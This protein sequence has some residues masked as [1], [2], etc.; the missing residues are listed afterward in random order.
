LREQTWNFEG[1]DLEVFK[2]RV[3]LGVFK[4]RV[5]LEV[6]KERVGLEVL[7]AYLHKQAQRSG[8]EKEWFERSGGFE[9][10]GTL[11]EV[12]KTKKSEPCGTLLN[13]Q[14]KT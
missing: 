1:V 8:K 4:E 13:N 2:E 5:G 14:K 12:E 3:E 6:F 9:G 10:S 7:N 11:T